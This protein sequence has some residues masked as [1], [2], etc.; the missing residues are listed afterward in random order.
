MKR[1][2]VIFKHLI[3]YLDNRLQIPC[4]PL[5]R[6][7]E[8]HL[9]TVHKLK[10]FRKEMDHW[11]IE[12]PV[13][14]DLLILFKTKPEGLSP[15]ALGK[16]KEMGPVDLSGMVWSNQIPFDRYKPVVFKPDHGIVSSY[17]G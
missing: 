8:P 3:W 17:F 5:T 9:G 16:W 2:P 10:D 13:L 14:L 1:D 6:S 7:G 4:Q 12:I 11:Q 15:S